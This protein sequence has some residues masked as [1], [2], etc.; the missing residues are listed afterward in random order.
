MRNALKIFFGSVSVYLIMAAC[1]GGGSKS[2]GSGD[3]PS[4][5]GKSGTGMAMSGR[6]SGGSAG[7]AAGGNGV[8][9]SIND[10]SMMDAIM[11]AIADAVP[12]AVPDADA[13]TPQEDTVSCTANGARTEAVMNY[14]GSTVREFAN[15]VVYAANANAAAP[16]TH[17][18]PLPLFRD[19]VVFVDCGT[20]MNPIYSSVTFI[21]P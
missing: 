4:Y 19:G 10:G 6:G 14:P 7:N 8:G 17:A 16:Y 3:D 20:V 18:R 12:D 13:Q 5:S 15:V 21:R 1:A 11:D 9:G 2:N